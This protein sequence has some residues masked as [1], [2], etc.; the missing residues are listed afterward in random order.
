MPE[1]LGLGQ[2]LRIPLLGLVRIAQFPEDLHHPGEVGDPEMRPLV[3]SLVEG[4]G[5]SLRDR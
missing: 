4:C 1:L 5:V 3:E 2:Q